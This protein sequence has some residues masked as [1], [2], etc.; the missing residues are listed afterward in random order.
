MSLSDHA[1]EL[2]AENLDSL[3]EVLK[4]FINWNQGMA[5]L[6]AALVLILCNQFIIKMGHWGPDGKCLAWDSGNHRNKTLLRPLGSL[7]LELF[8]PAWWILKHDQ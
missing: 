6:E 1:W 8:P 3:Y 5:A 2:Q 4:L 7:N